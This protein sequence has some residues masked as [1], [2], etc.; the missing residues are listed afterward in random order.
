M[1]IDAG[2]RRIISVAERIATS[3][4]F[5][6]QF[7]NSLLQMEIPYTINR[8]LLKLEVPKLTQGS[9]SIVELQILSNILSG[10]MSRSTL[11]DTSDLTDNP[12]YNYNFFVVY[13]QGS[14]KVNPTSRKP[15]FSVGDPNP[16]LAVIYYSSFYGLLGGLT[17]RSLRRRRKKIF[18]IT[19]CQYYGDTKYTYSRSE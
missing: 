2:S 10:N 3:D 18:F 6:P 5:M 16:I 11:S 4:V 1:T 9:G 14:V 7:N 19:R 12:N 13:D 15:F 8:S 17:Y